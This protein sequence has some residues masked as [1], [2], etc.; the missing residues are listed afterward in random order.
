M[1]SPITIVELREAIAEVIAI[2]EKAYDVPCIC[3]ALGLSPG[4]TNE[5]F[6]S[7]R[8]YVRSRI[9]TKGINELI[10]LGEKLLERYPNA[11]DLEKMINLFKNSSTGVNG[12]IKNLIFAADGPKPELVLVDALDNSIEIVENAEYCLV[13]DLPISPTGLL[14][15]H[16]VEWWAKKCNLPFPDKKTEHHLFYRLKKSLDLKSPPEHLLFET[17]FKYFH[18]QL[19]ERLPALPGFLTS[20]KNKFT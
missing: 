17:Y 20:S 10:N 15:I 9:I 7:K 2:N 5:A 6:S 14:W 4:E 16:L 8:V 18:P 13:Y 19:K 3:T 11:S 1:S 12:Y